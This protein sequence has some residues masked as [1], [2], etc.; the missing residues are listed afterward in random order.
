MMPPTAMHASLTRKD[1][2]ISICLLA[3]VLAAL[4]FGI[5]LRKRIFDATAGSHFQGDVRS[6]WLWGES[7]MRYGLLDYYE[8]NI[9]GGPPDTSRLTDYTPLRLALAT[10]WTRWTHRHYPEVNGWQD[11]YD[12]TF[13]MLTT[14]TIAELISSAFIFLTIWVL[15]RRQ[16]ADQLGPFTGVWQALLGAMLFWFNPAVLWDGHCW[17]QWDVWLLPFFFAAV[18]LAS[19]E[20]WLTAGIAIAVG[21]FLKGQILLAAPIF[22]LWPI[23]AGKFGAL[24]KFVSGFAL[25]SALIALPWMR[26]SMAA[27]I[28]CGGIA[29]LMIGLNWLAVRKRFAF[30]L[31]P[32]LTALALAGAIFAI[33]PMFG[34]KTAWYTVGFKH[35][36]EKFENMMAGNGVYNVPKL[37]TQSLG[38]PRD[39]SQPVRVPLI[40]SEIPFRT[41]E[42]IIYGVCLLICGIGA[43][44]HARKRDVRFVAAMVAPWLCFYLLLPQMHGRYG[45][46]AAGAAALLA[47]IGVG[48]ALL[49]LLVSIIACMGIIQNQY[50]FVPEYAPQVLQALQ[51]IDP[52]PVFA[53]LLIAGILLCLCVPIPRVAPKTEIPQRRTDWSTAAGSAR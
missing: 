41:S 16:R 48:P 11:D 43:A 47:A 42:W 14:N 4:I 34:A 19:V 21:A 40:G 24:L 8:L 27:I 31:L 53:L 36:T 38:W 52:H 39:P 18:L 10:A 51:T 12:F 50:L 28:W 37:L 46:W 45:V 9:N 32:A 25:A 15:V 7:A 20:W 1:R 5:W 17:P 26:P 23:C 2:I 13:P 6:A 33:I 35:G 49:G 3:A 22:I 30:N 29:A 44:V